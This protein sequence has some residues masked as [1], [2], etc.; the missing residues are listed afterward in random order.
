MTELK[1]YQCGHCDFGTGQ[2]GMDRCAKCDGT[3]SVFI[4]G[5]RR[6]PNTKEGYEAACA[7]LTATELEE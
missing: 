2:R 3:G 1:A 7:A 4:V 6:F 5:Q